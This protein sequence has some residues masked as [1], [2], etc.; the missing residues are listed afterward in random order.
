MLR[1]TSISMNYSIFFKVL[2]VSQLLTAAS[3]AQQVPIINYSVNQNGQAELEINSKADHYYILKIKRSL[4]IGFEVPTSMT[5][6]RAGKTI[7]RE[8]LGAYPVEEYQ[9]FEYPINAPRDTDQDGIDDITEYGATPNQNPINAAQTISTDDGV[10][11]IDSFTTFKKL[12][13]RK[14]WVQFSEYLNGLGFFK[15]LITDYKSSNPKVFFINTN[16]HDLHKSFADEIGEDY[17]GDNIRK[18]QIVYHPTSISNNGNLGT[19]AFNYTGGHGDD[20]DI[21]LRTHELLAASMPFLKNNLSYF[22]TDNGKDEYERDIDSFNNSRIP[23]LLEEDVY[24]DVDYWG[25]NQAEGYGFFKKIELDEVPGTKDIV[26]YDALPN[27]L[28]RVGGIITSVIQTPLS[29]VNLRAIQNKVPNAFIRDPLDV[30]SIADLLNHYI[31]FKVEQDKYTIR[32]A[33]VEEVNAWFENIRPEQEQTPPLNLCIKEILPLEKIGFKLFDAFGAKCA[34]L[35]TMRTFDLPAGTI[36]NGYGIPF[37]YYQEFM[38][39]HGFFAEAKQIIERKDFKLDR[40]LR[41]SLLS[42]FR[43]K[44]RA[45]TMPTWMH[46]DLS[47]LQNSFPSGTSIRCRSSTNNE[48][49]P[50]F[51]G[52][53]LY[54]SKTQHPIEG[55]ISKSIKQVYASLWNLRAFEERDFYRINHFM[56]SMGVLCHPNFQDELANGVGVSTDPLY[57]TNSTFYL[58]TQI[59]EELITNPDSNARPEEIL[60]DRVSVSSNN[61]IVLQRSNLVKEDSTILSEQHLSEMREF[62]TIIHDEFTKLY[63]AE[64]SASFAMDI[65]YKITKEDQLIIKQA[66]PWVSYVIPDYTVA[67]EPDTYDVRLYPNPAAECISVACEDCNLAKISIT[68]LTGKQVETKIIPNEHATSIHIELRGLP[69]GIYILNA[70]LENNKRVA[71]KKFLKR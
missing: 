51:N 49:L 40:N 25:L 57:N 20:F 67:S 56:A 47:A 28:P 38:K 43:K 50:G 29:H 12:S 30:D 69:T 17:L 15:F 19:F 10:I 26:L 3:Y 1:Y 6:G 7:L 18:G 33:T 65:E 14:D 8:P 44:I 64:N 48:D 62:L 70:Y 31:Y 22:I 58:N 9:V 36:P 21:V 60:L 37:Y 63:G 35:A 53:G 61:Y 4:P 71:S 24:A 42:D 27:A 45:A 54:T 34:N 11:L 55:H 2:L 41:D 59:G 39:Y 66:R 23:V 52:A 46:N 16:K 68:S 13:I 32:E 5:L